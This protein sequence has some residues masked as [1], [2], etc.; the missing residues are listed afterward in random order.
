MIYAG[1]AP[2]DDHEIIE[3][4]SRLEDVLGVEIS[5]HESSKIDDDTGSRI[6]QLTFG[7][8]KSVHKCHLNLQMGEWRMRKVWILLLL[9][10]LRERC[11]VLRRS[12]LSH[13][14]FRDLRDS[15]MWIEHFDIKYL[16]DSGIS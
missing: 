5:T 12:P 16:L 6:S 9:K 11:S 14:F 13:Y 4:C 3:E 7:K 10:I 1:S 8:T 2:N 15:I